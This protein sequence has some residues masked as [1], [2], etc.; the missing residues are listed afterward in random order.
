MFGVWVVRK[1]GKAK[2]IYIYISYFGMFSNYIHD[3]EFFFL[4]GV[5]V[6][7]KCGK[8][9]RNSLFF[10][11]FSFFVFDLFGSKKLEAT[12]N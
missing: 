12:E 7:R 6:L 8:V 4:L 1:C 5:W 3:F 11:F 9:K 10:F 2:E